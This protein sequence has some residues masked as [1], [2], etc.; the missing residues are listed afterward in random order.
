MLIATKLEREN[1]VA[2]MAYMQNTKN[3]KKAQKRYILE[4]RVLSLTGF[5]SVYA[6][7]ISGTRIEKHEESKVRGKTISGIIIP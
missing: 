7:E 1:H 3:P 5:L 2:K 6:R 4:I